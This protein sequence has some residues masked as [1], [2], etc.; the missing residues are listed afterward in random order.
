M[1]IYNHIIRSLSMAYPLFLTDSLGTMT[2]SDLV[3]YVT[4]SQWFLKILIDEGH[5]FTFFATV[6]FDNIWRFR[7]QIIF[8]EYIP[9][10]TKE[11]EK[12]NKARL[13]HLSAWFLLVSTLNSCWCHPQSGWVKV[14]FNV[15][16]RPMLLSL[17]LCVEMNLTILCLPTQISFPLH[18][19]LKG[20]AHVTFQTIAL[21]VHHEF[22]YVIFEG[23]SKGIIEAPLQLHFSPPWFF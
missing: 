7:N 8:I 1:P 17:L 13:D 20:E 12:I 11:V 5:K 2:P 21:V 9:N 3:K 23:D 4:F 6:L 10:P 18:I 19:F 22:Q 16:I 14:N 15:T